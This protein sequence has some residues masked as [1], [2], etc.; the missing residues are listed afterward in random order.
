MVGRAR[1]LERYGLSTEIEPRWWVLS[2]RT[3]ADHGLAEER[4][5][6]QYVRRVEAPQLTLENS[7]APASR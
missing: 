7:E 4:G 1:R 3:E 6:S 5:I 2:D